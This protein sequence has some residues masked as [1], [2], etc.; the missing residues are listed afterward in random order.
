MTLQVKLQDHQGWT[1][2][3][4]VPPC[5]TGMHGLQCSAHTTQL[6]LVSRCEVACVSLRAAVCWAVGSSRYSALHKLC[7][8]QCPRGSVAGLVWLLEQAGFSSVLLSTALETYHV[9]RNAF[10]GFTSI[11][12]CSL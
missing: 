9:G 3:F 1:G 12:T 7:V 5:S 8:Q 2:A 11:I 4:R 10:T 6:G